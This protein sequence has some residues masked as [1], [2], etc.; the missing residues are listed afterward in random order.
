MMQLKKLDKYAEFVGEDCVQQIYKMGAKLAEKSMVHVNSTYYGGGVAEMLTSYIPLLN[1]AGLKTEWRLL[2]GDR[3]F[4]MVTKKMHNSLQGMKVELT[5]EDITTYEATISQNSSFMN[6]E[7]YDMV[8]IDDPQPCGM[9]AHYRRESPSLYK[10]LPLLLSL[11]ELQKKQ[12]WVWRC[13]L[14]LTSPN[15][16]TWRY[17]KKYLNDYEAIVVSARK[18]KTS[19]RKPHYFMA[20]AIDPLSEKNRRLS[21]WEV[22]RELSRNGIDSQ[23]PMILQVSRF[24]PWKD[25]LGVIHAY[26]KVKKEI[27]CQLVLMGGMA[28]D[29]PEGDAIFRN[30]YSEAEKD[31]D[32]SLL[33]VQSDRLVNALQRRADVVVQKSLR[34]GF[35]L[36]VTEAM[37]KGKPVVASR[38][39]GIPLQIENRVNGLLCDGID[40]CATKISY[41]LKHK[42]EA[43]AIGKNAT[44]KV[45]K[46]FLVTRLVRDELELFQA[47]TRG[48]I[49]KSL[50]SS[51][52]MLLSMLLKLGDLPPLKKTVPFLKRVHEW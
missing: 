46:D 2:R 49:T 28:A 32:I 21:S 27:D 13:H 8:V 52:Q 31:K 1:E 3:D 19:L 40:D 47:I 44:E 41:L 29:D 10:P 22:A 45:R 36:T 42:R 4:F 12:P 30:A 23:K 14:D 39:G 26:R 33:T 16:K 25:P 50:K 48:F 43:E 34:E 51:E 15:R 37:W 24:D 7:W 6:L 35:G 38:V 11:A 20:P 17:L 9:V 18:Y 5:S